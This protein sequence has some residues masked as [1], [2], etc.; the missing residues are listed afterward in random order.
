MSRI[1]IFA[2]AVTLAHIA[3]PIAL[4]RILRELGH[5][6]CIAAAEEAD[7]W[8]D[9][10]P[11]ARQ[12]ITSIASTD[13]LRALRRGLPP[14]DTRT[15][16]RYVEDDLRAMNA[17]VP[18]I[19]IGDFRLSLYIS[20]R[21]AAKPYGAIA[22]AY[23][24]RRYWRCAAHAPE[25]TALRRLP[26]GFADLL[27]R[28]S[29]PVAFAIHALPFHRAC[30]HF[31]V[32]PPGLDIRDVYTASDATAFADVEGLYRSRQDAGVRFIGPLFWHA[33][34]GGP[35]AAPGR[36]DPV[37][38]VALGSSGHTD[39]LSALLTLL[40]E[41]PWRYI[42]ATHGAPTVSKGRNCIRAAEF[43]SYEE[44]C[45][46]ADIMVCN[47]GAPATYAS[48]A[49]GTPVLGLAGNLDQHLNMGAVERAG[50]GICIDFR[51]L[52][53]PAFER[54]IRELRT[55]PRIAEGVVKVAAEIADK[56]DARP[57]VLEWVATLEHC[58]TRASHKPNGMSTGFT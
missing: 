57:P 32:D 18:D 12:R 17:W 16:R 22:N 11:V 49:T 40:E 4:S 52:T 51:D 24:S 29:Y 44:A 9:A 45:A 50:G 41:L 42:V 2:E 47:G 5:D 35:V 37:L 56:R 8:L 48:L 15:L 10:E 14:Y 6:V 27:F 36:G 31:A 34:T 55:S 30:K 19:V 21:L 1:L 33:A 54:A 23:W 3:R 46:T 43:I 39:R 13:F 38:F 25:I 53:G 28:H 7:R 20:A 26:R 58:L